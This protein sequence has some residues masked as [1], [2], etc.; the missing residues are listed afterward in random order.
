MAIIV[1]VPF[2]FAWIYLFNIEQVETVAGR[3]TRAAGTQ[4]KMEVSLKVYFS[5]AS[6]DDTKTLC[7]GAVTMTELAAQR[8]Y[9]M[10]RDLVAGGAVPST[11]VLTIGGMI[12]AAIDKHL[13]P[14]RNERSAFVSVQRNEDS[15]EL[16]KLFADAVA[17]NLVQRAN[18]DSM[19]IET[20]HQIGVPVEQTADKFSAVIAGLSPEQLGAMLASVGAAARD[21][22]IKSD[23][24]QSS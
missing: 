23:A 3:S 19:M 20:L 8:L 14:E 1:A 6:D 7:S 21:A 4:S 18:I 15:A 9:E 12:G 16:V 13:V 24:S 22:V 11:Q 17:I 10:H 5:I 2:Y